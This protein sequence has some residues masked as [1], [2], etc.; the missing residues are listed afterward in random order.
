MLSE[1]QRFLNKRALKKQPKP[2]RKPPLSLEQSKW[3]GIL[4]DATSIE[5][6]EATT[7]FVEQLRSKGKQVR[8]LAY[9]NDKSKEIA[10]PFPYF[11]KAEVNFLHIPSSNT[12]EN[13]MTQTF[14]V[15]FV[16]HP[17]STPL[18]EYITALTDA[19]L[20]VGPFSLTKD[21]FDF[22]VDM[23]GHSALHYFIN[24]VEFFLSKM[25]PSREAQVVEQK[26]VVE[27]EELVAA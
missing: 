26:T 22:M 19:R 9:V 24:Q 4:F 1:I 21:T 17:K 7:K 13:F 11:S 8:L 12:V 15:L 18:F 2:L 5:H 23:S 25:K 16:M 10:L 27:Q 3:V 6:I 14:D 20:K